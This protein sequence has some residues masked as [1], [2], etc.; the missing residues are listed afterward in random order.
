ME[1]CL[2]K[3]IFLVGRDNWQRNNALNHKLLQ[4][5]RDINYRIIWEDP[6]S[7]FIYQ[8]RRQ[9]NKFQWLPG[10]LKKFN[11]RFARLLYGL[12]HPRYFAYLSGRKKWD[13]RCQLLKNAIK[14]LGTGYEIFILSMSSGGRISSL[15]ADEV[16]IK[17]IICLAY[18]FKNPHKD[19]EPERYQHLENLKTPMLII[20]GT[21]DEYGGIDA[22]EKYPLSNNIEMFYVDTNHDFNMSDEDW[23]TVIQKI[24]DIINN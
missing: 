6:A 11:L 24:I 14:Q 23:E 4:Y 2:N 10:V 19:D 9:E 8:L 3:I 21:R 20:Q 1:S 15:I 7:E 13:I 5:L 22:K 18:P 17:H 16:N 12:R